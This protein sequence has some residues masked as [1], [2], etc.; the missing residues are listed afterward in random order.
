[1]E[2]GESLIL[3]TK[4]IAKNVWVLNT[5]ASFDTTLCRKF[6]KTFQSGNFGKLFVADESLNI[7]G[8]VAVCYEMLAM[9][10]SLKIIQFQVGNCSLKDVM[11]GLN[12]VNRR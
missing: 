11:L 2:N 7:I 9:S 1:M 10:L 6:F 8:K 3:T 5:G 12:L 4:E